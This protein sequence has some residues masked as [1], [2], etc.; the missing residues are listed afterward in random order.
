MPLPQ[1]D[2]EAGKE[3]R[4]CVLV[5]GGSEQV[6]GAV[7]LAATA[8]LRSG[9]GKLQIATS[10]RVALMI[11]VSVP[12]ARVIGLGQ[13][14]N[15]ELA[16][17]SYRS[18]QAEID[19]CDAL[20]VGPG[21]MDGRAAAEVIRDCLKR[22]R[23][24]A[25][26]V[27]A[28]ALH[29]FEARKP[30]APGGRAIPVLTPHAG[31]MAALWGMKKESVLAAPLQIAREAAARLRAIIVLKG[32]QTFVATPDGAVYHNDAGND[33]LGVSGS[34]DTLSGIISGLC[35]RGADPLRGALWGVYL[36]ARAG[37]ALA[38]RCGQDGYLARQ[39]PG[40]VP[41]L[42]ANLS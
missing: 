7:I 21:M 15:G 27:D 31:E 41:P 19:G 11:A 12:E 35:A 29:A 32:A 30:L 33:G 34:G 42:L 24:P 36:H 1:V 22:P 25:L 37:D 39:L 14:R 2:G 9:A 13:T 20:L 3:G 23:P 16:P 6:P 4:G 8:A 17:H 5:V 38:R 40:E 26:I 10:R 18:L 28:A